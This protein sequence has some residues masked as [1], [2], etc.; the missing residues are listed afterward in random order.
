MKIIAINGWKNSG[1]TSLVERLTA[2]FIRRGFSVSTIK[3]A[4]RNFDI[5]QPGTDSD[6]H[7]AAGASEVLVSSPHRWALM[8]ESREGEASL[9]ALLDKLSPV[10]IVIVE[11]FKG[12]TLAPKIETRRRESAAGDSL[13]R[14]DPQVIAV[15]TDEPSSAPTDPPEFN[16]ANEKAIADFILQSFKTSLP[17]ATS[18]TGLSA[19]PPGVD[20]MPVDIALSR[21]R[22]TI[23]VS[24]GASRIKVTEADGRILAHDVR[25]LRSSPPVTNSAVDGYGFRF[26]EIYSAKPECTLKLIDGRAAAGEPFDETVWDGHAIRV[27]TGAPLP[28][29]VDTI[30]M[31]E[32]SRID[33]AGCVHF[34]SPKK[35]GENTRQAGE[36]LRADDLLFEASRLVR[37][38]DMASMMAAGLSKVW[39]RR[40][41]RVGLIS[42]GNELVSKI[43]AVTPHDFTI[44]ANRP[45]LKSIIARWGYE[46]ID[47]GIVQDKESNVCET[48]DQASQ[49]A[50]AILISGG[51]SSGDEDYV[52]RLLMREG[53]NLA[54]RIAIK[55]GRPLAL[56]RWSGI[57]I[58]ALP[59]NPVAAMV[60]ML[61]FSRPALH[62]LAGGRWCEPIH[63]MMP[64]DFEKIKKA[65]RREYIRARM[66][67]AG[68]IEAFHSEGSG[69]TTGLSWADGLVE[70]SDGAQTI[71]R[72]DQVRYLPY[73]SF[74]L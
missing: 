6:R 68:R 73:S 53:E 20:W 49:S 70:L 40:P 60:C 62:V 14:H 65:G 38:P 43:T 5:D 16:L 72:G 41:L 56:A 32:F 74:G 39:V 10:D 13:A 50:D 71:S 26:H 12:T 61:I 58:F 23:N 17:L 35:C 54:W 11:G 57:P 25:V 28:K 9:E 27:L 69:L 47:F 2:E 46:A 15:A 66:N 55:P 1:K 34:K 21:L 18:E 36:D 44:D 8:H 67:Q 63:F 7:R 37:A 29:G 3:H 45:L 64:A 42:T 52:S 19:M 48:L 4:H 22:E 31:D 59:G 30:V 24:V 51:A 33:E